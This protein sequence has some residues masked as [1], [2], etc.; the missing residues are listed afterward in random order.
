MSPSDAV[1]DSPVIVT[2]P[3][4]GAF[5]KPKD[6][7]V[8]IYHRKNDSTEFTAIRS[9]STSSPRCVVRDR[10]L[11]I[12]LNH[13]SRFRIAAK[14]TRIFIGK[15]VICTPIIPVSP[16]RN[17]MP[18]FLVNVRDQNVAE[19]QISKIR[20]GYEDP[21]G[22]VPFL[23]MWRSG[24]LKVTCMESTLKDKAKIIQERE[25]RHLTEHKETFEVDTQNITEDK[26]NLHIT[27]EQSTT[28]TFEVPMSLKATVISEGGACSLLTF[29]TSSPSAAIHPAK[30]TDSAS[31]SKTMEVTGAM[32]NKL[33]SHIPQSA[34]ISLSY[35]LGIEYNNAQSILRKNV[36]DIEKAAREC[37]GKWKDR[38]HRHVCDLHEVLEA[39]DI[40]GL[41]NSLT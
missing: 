40:G 26:F 23:F 11:D 21:I 10:D 25:F 8:F 30:T 28:K 32:L 13:F 9:T 2:M 41:I 1:F 35:E 6:A 37:L 19:G 7:E 20:E 36:N 5:T 12:Y 39:A 16:P 31:S 22:G 17:P 27:L 29:P 34:Y 33:A 38:K 4:C 3:H 24:G 14:L 18:V 15:C